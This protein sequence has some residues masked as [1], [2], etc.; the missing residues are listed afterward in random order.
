MVVLSVSLVVDTRYAR[1]RCSSAL[2]DSTDSW[3]DCCVQVRVTCLHNWGLFWESLLYPLAVLLS[4]ASSQALCL[5]LVARR[6]GDTLVRSELR[7]VS[8]PSRG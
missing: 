5:W 3:N 4:A 7:L 2:G 1:A 6:T 8:R